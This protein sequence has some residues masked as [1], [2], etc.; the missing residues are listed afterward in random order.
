MVVVERRNPILLLHTCK[1]TKTGPTYYGHVLIFLQSLK[2]KCCI[3]P[4][5]DYP[6]YNVRMRLNG[7]YKLDSCN[8]ITVDGG[9]GRAALLGS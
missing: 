6:S 4:L 2:L 3:V 5:R 9:V 8:A 1:G 7:L